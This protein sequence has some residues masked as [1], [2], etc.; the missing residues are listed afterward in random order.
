MISRLALMLSLAAAG[1]GTSSQPADTASKVAKCESLIVSEDGTKFEY[2]AGVLFSTTTEAV[3][4]APIENRTGKKVKLGLIRASCACSGGVQVDAKS[5]APGES[6]TMSFQ[7]RPSQ[8]YGAQRLRCVV[9]IDDDKEWN[10][11]LL[12]YVHR[13]IAFL[14]HGASFGKIPLSTTTKPLELQYTAKTEQEFPTVT[15]LVVHAD[16]AK[17]TLGTLG[18]VMHLPNGVYQRNQ[19]VLVEVTPKITG[20]G[21]IRIDARYASGTT[22]GEVQSNVMWQA[23]GPVTA[24]PARCH[25]GTYSGERITREIT[26]TRSDG[27]AS[28]PTVASVPAGIGCEFSPG[29][30]GIYVVKLTL[31]PSERK[32]NLFDSLAIQYPDNVTFQLPVSAID[33]R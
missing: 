30:P 26:L 22:T 6:T 25:F 32:H 7:L 15:A 3:V 14:D 13:P 8:M 23:I 5:L 27:Y 11:E 9:Q 29:A 21:Q 4:K 24:S 12:A 31:S 20:F 19:Q 1:C 33:G 2:D 28:A 17:A 18:P 16:N 10:Y